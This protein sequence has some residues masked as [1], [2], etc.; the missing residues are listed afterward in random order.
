MANNALPAA[1]DDRHG[2]YERDY[3]TWA[4]EQAHALKEHRTE[5]LDWKNLA[6]EV[7]GLGRGERRE[8]RSRLKVLLAHLLNGNFSRDAELVAGKP[9]SRCN[10][11]RYD[12]ICETI[13]D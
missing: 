9:R 7:E 13:Q 4:V 10:A 2:L 5:A 8:L 1:V 12:S 6:E 3:N 11:S